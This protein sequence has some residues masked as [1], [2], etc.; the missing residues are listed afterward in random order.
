MLVVFTTIYLID[1]WIWPR[2]T[3]D[4]AEEFN[5]QEYTANPGKYGDHEFEV[6]K[7]AASQNKNT[8]QR[9]FSV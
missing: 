7:T 5:Y 6:D 1:Q 2:E 8:K 9:R 3:I 4:I